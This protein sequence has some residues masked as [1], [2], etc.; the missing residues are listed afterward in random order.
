MGEK[1]LSAKEEAFM[2][3]ELKM[4][5]LKRRA[6]PIVICLILVAGLLWL[7]AFGAFKIIRGPKPMDSLV[8][9]SRFR[10]Q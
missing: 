1:G 7:S 9:P 10:G 5:S 8:C 4:K 2:L 6:V 3:Q